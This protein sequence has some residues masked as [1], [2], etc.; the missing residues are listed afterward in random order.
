MI[1]LSSKKVPYLKDA[2]WLLFETAHASYAFLE[3]SVIFILF[4]VGSICAQARLVVF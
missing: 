2:N 3:K 4:V 1:N